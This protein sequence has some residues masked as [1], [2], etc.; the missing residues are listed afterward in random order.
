MKHKIAMWAGAGLLIAVGWALYA[1]AAP[2][3]SQ[4]NVVTLARLTQ[5]IV[6]AGSY[7]HFGLNVGWVLL[8]NTATYALIGMMAES[9]SALTPLIKRIPYH[10]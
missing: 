2:M 10:R 1:L 5:P 3:S 6:L 9:F 7:F 8:A 4:A